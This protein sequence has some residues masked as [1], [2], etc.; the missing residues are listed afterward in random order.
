MFSF[1]RRTSF[2]RAQA[3]CQPVVLA[4]PNCCNCLCQNCFSPS[5][6]SAIL[7]NGIFFTI[8]MKKTKYLVPSHD[9][10]FNSKALGSFDSIKKKISAI[11]AELIWQ[12]RRAMIK[13][14][15]AFF[16]RLLIT[17]R[18]KSVYAFHTNF[19]RKKIFPN[20]FF[21]ILGHFKNVFYKLL[22]PYGVHALNGI[23]PYSFIIFRIRMYL[24]YT[25]VKL[26]RLFLAFV[27]SQLCDRGRNKNLLAYLNCMLCNVY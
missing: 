27:V 25:Y 16:L 24:A 12:Q 7:N 9:K 10:V 18:S 2:V 23:F 6:I 13:K 14:K 22:K 26:V 1:A 8:W 4:G 19:P 5:V 15:Q 3:T 17:L 20:I 21:E 11:Y